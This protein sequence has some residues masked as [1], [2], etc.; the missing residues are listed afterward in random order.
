[1]STV[2]EIVEI[3]DEITIEMTE[4]IKNG[5]IDKI[6]FL[7]DRRQNQIDM[8]KVADGKASD[9]N[10]SKLLNDLRIFDDLFKEKMKEIEKKIDELSMNIEALRGYSFTD[11]SHTF[12]ERR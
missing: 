5:R 7:M 1:M 8:L 3:I 11:N 4:E 9:G 2:E 6:Q 10:I 12:D